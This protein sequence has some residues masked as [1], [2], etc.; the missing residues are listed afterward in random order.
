MLISRKMY[1]DFGSILLN[2]LINFNFC[3]DNFWVSV[4]NNYITHKL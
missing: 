4:K 2:S 1:I 3:V